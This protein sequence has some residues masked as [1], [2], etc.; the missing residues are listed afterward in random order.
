MEAVTQFTFETI[1]NQ[2][3]MTAMAKALR[4][5][6]RRKRNRRI[7]IFGWIA[8]AL[9]ILVSLLP[10]EAGITINFK[11]V[12][13]WLAVLVILA[14]LLFE[15]QLNGTVAVRRLPPG[16][17]KA[18]VTF[19]AEGYNSSTELGTSQFTYDHIRMLAET[20]QYFVLEFG[21]NHAQVYDKSS[22]TGGT[23]E[24]FRRFIE[25]ATGKQ[26]QQVK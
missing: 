9:G 21:A 18:T 20:P 19:T 10:G 8:A 13:T 17:T 14:A 25:K 23:V 16:T 11:T 15:D 12:I 3:S 4:K 24:D 7:R 2:K 6:V 22:I 1:Y 5:T 26:V